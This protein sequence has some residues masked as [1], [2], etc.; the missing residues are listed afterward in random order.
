MERVDLAGMQADEGAVLRARLP[1]SAARIASG[2][3]FSAFFSW[4]SWPSVSNARASVPSS[5]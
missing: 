2:L 4:S 5:S 1:V 3:A